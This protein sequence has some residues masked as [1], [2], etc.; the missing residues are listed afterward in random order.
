MNRRFYIICIAAILALVGPA[1]ANSTSTVHGS[2]YRWDT[3]KPLENS[4]VEVNSTPS[5]S[6]VAKYGVYS[7]DLVPGDYNIT[8]FYYQNNSAIYSA[9]EIIKIKD[10]GNYV[11]DLLLFPVYS[12][13]LM[14][15]SEN[16]SKSTENSSNSIINTAVSN[17]E[18]SK[19]SSNNTNSA[20]PN[21]A[22]FINA[23]YLLITAF[24]LLILLSGGYYI[25]RRNKEIK[26]NQPQKMVY[27]NGKG[28]IV[29]EP[30]KY[31]KVS[32]LPVEVY[33]KIEIPYDD[34]K[35]EIK[36]ESQEKE[37]VK[38]F[39]TV[40]AIEEGA[41][42]VNEPLKGQGEEPVKELEKEMPLNEI[43]SE[44]VEKKI[45]TEPVEIRDSS[46]AKE[47][48]PGE[49]KLQTEKEE[50][51]VEKSD[52]ELK[53]SSKIESSDSIKKLPLPTDLQEIMDIIRGQGG[54]ITQKDLRSKLK[55]SEG[56][57]SLML[58]DL[59]R[60]ELVEKFKRGRGNVV[61]IRDEQR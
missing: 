24:L 20:D 4:V 22:G 13:E 52:D 6:M 2:V 53:E 11:R 30:S 26:E 8:A 9:T 34:I 43:K 61:I 14:S 21:S 27:I 57:V 31:V 15:S 54:R 49:S 35:P 48:E 59:E 47:I 38:S 10:Q 58:A 18:S 40:S 29:T 36:Q 46:S 12:E 3:F 45:P 56:K 37:L 44:I 55:Y 42:P 25:S 60:R 7:F 50:T 39:E 5:Q 32:D 17:I 19:S 23:P 41:E 51:L 33:D 16:Q 28:H 1:L